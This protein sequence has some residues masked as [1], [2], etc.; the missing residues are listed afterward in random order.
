MRYAA[1]F[2]MLSITPA[3]A[4]ETTLPP[5]RYR[6]TVEELAALPVIHG[7][8]YAISTT[9]HGHEGC[10]FP[11]L[12]LAF[13]PDIGHGFTLA[14]Q[15]RATAHECGHSKGWTSDHPEGSL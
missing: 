14:D 5:A 6:C 1:L 2:L 11:A 15:H 10:Y 4:W 3:L 8:Y 7:D 9:C 12:H 13:I